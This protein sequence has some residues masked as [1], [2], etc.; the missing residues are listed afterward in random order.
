MKFT[1]KGSQGAGWSPPF[2]LPEHYL[3]LD[4]SKLHYFT[5]LQPS[6]KEAPS[7]DTD[8]RQRVEMRWFYLVYYGEKT[9]LLRY[10]FEQDY[11][12]D[13]STTEPTDEQLSNLIKD[14]Y[15]QLQNNFGNK[16]SDFVVFRPVE[17]I[18]DPEV[19][20]AILDLRK[21]FPYSRGL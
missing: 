14:S 21:L 17:N 12:I 15:G 11:Y 19:Q 10:D 5:V 1:R 16:A 9:R 3:Q 18:T 4:T 20:Q 13:E 6:F 7:H 2:F 8:K